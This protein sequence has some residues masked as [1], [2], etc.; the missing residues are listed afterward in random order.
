MNDILFPEKVYFKNHFT[1]RELVLVRADCMEISPAASARITSICNQT[2]VY[3]NLFQERLKSAPYTVSD[4]VEFLAW[5]SAGWRL[6][7]HFVF[8]II[9]DQFGIV[10]A[11]DSQSAELDNAEIGYW[12]DANHPGNVTNAVLAMVNSALET[13]FVRFTAYV[14]PENLKSSRVLE[15]AGF[16]PS[17]GAQER[18]G[19]VCLERRNTSS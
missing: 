8:F 16:S 4:A 1:E 11:I 18:D 5:A 6:G 12:A 3:H 7:T 10:G 9:H 15:R 17:L 2:T 13:G 14:R 19:F